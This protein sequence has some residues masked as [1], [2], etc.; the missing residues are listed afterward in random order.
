MGKIWFR[1]ARATDLNDLVTLLY[2]LFSIEKDFEFDADKQRKGLEMMLDHENTVVFVAEAESRTIG[3]CTGQLMISTAEGGF[4][5][6]VEDV[7]VAESWHGKGVGTQ[8]LRELE[9][10]ALEKKV[11]RLQLLA[12]RSNTAGVA[13][14]EKQN[15]QTTQLFCLRKRLTQNQK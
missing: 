6:L 8:L 7:V 5:L 2:L 11:S 4:S 3:M 9:T 14:Y 13:F 12:D 15:W 10:W 1:R